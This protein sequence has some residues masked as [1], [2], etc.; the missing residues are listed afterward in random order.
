MDSPKL[1]LQEH[2]HNGDY[3]KLKTIISIGDFIDSYH[4]IRLNG[5]GFLLGRL[6]GVT[7]ESKVKRAWSRSHDMSPEWWIVPKIQKRLRIIV[8]GDE[9]VDFPEYFVKKYL[10][11][12]SGLRMLS[13]GCGSGTKEIEYAKYDNF[14]LIEGFDI[15]EHNINAAKN[16][17][18]KSGHTNLNF[19]VGNI[20]EFEPESES[21]S[22]DII[23]FH[24]SLHHIDNVK[25]LLG[26]VKKSLKQDGLLVIATEYVGPNFL[27]W[28]SNQLKVANKILKSLPDKYK[29]RVKSNKIKARIYRPGRL[30]ML[31]QDPSEA[32]DS[33][34]IIPAL[35]EHFNVLEEKMV[36]GNI[37][38]I[39]LKDIAQ[40]FLNDDQETEDLL[41]K[42]ISIE[43]NFIKENNT[44]DYIVGIYKK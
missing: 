29:K 15:S 34:N 30:R 16:H 28:S 9:N 27:Q 44:S 8:Q 13:P 18:L 25:E 35:R 3:L 23:I 37:L 41:N 22:Y 42:L 7:L 2:L 20:Y 10:K 39:L 11:N 21:Q 26:R 38:S 32:V 24:S 36:G 31:L 14:E 6:F 1:V 12:K 19:F 4:K 43:E 33:E 40:N 17:M 5:I